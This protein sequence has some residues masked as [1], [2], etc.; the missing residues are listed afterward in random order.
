[1]VIVNI[2]I[3]TYKIRKIKYKNIMP[4]PHIRT[5]QEIFN[6]PI[7][8]CNVRF[9]Q[10]GQS[11]SPR[12]YSNWW[13]DGGPS[14]A[15]GN[16]TDFEHLYTIHSAVIN[17]IRP[18][19]FNCS[20][21]SEDV[22]RNLRDRI[23]ELERKNN[24]LE[25]E[26]QEI[27]NLE[28]KSYWD[29]LNQASKVIKELKTENN[30]LQQERNNLELQ[31][32]DL[33]D[34]IGRKQ[35]AISL[36]NDT[37]DSLK[38]SKEKRQ[39]EI[40]QLDKELEELRKDSEKNKD[41]IRKLEREKKGFEEDLEITNER[42]KTAEE[43]KQKLSDGLAALKL[44]SQQSTTTN[45]PAALFN[46]D[47]KKK[48]DGFLRD[49]MITRNSRYEEMIKEASAELERRDLI[50]ENEEFQTKIEYYVNKLK[51]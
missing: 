28:G 27:N 10:D 11:F 7:S 18:G 37:I 33:Q 20:C 40:L 25:K 12:V 42:L 24:E 21:E 48:L 46:E 30:S 6:N 9:W 3:I 22:V 2:N 32:S 47:E 34:D 50:K 43:E 8:Y 13:G 49:Y 19:A 1:V 31:K 41:E 4:C 51:N 45:L 29:K 36:K 38:Q 16:K 5:I 17:A 26:K 14:L 23:S 39:E 44:E 15:L 35:L